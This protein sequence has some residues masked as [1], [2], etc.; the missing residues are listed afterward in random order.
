M[1]DP[2]DFY[3]AKFVEFSRQMAPARHQKPFRIDVESWI[4]SL[5]NK[6]KYDLSKKLHAG[7]KKKHTYWTAISRGLLD[8]F[9][10]K[11]E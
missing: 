9:Y 5:D 10:K 2:S 4:A 6:Q 7:Y 8:L 1:T 3:I 11:G